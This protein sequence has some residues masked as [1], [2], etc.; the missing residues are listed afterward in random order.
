MLEMGFVFTLWSVKESGR[1]TERGVRAEGEGRGCR[2][3]APE[4]PLKRKRAAGRV[5]LASQAG[6]RAGNM[7]VFKS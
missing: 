4:A 3:D 7:C 5:P 2:R 1:D 6:G